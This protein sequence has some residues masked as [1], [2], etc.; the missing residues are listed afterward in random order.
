MKTAEAAK[1]LGISPVTL[2]KHTERGVI[3]GRVLPGRRKMYLYHRAALEE[4]MLGRE[5]PQK[6]EINCE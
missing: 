6:W 1:L 2:R 3:P 5:V 4:F